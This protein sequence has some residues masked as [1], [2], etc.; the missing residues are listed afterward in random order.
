[1]NR[2]LLL[3]LLVIAGL[4]FQPAQ[5]MKAEDGQ[6]GYG[7]QTIMVY[8][9]G[10][11]LESEGG[12]ATSDIREMLQARPDKERLN[13]LVMTGGTTRWT[14]KI[15]SRDQLGVYRIEGANPKLVHQ[16]ESASMGEADTL[17][18]FLE[19]AVSAY[20]ADSYGLVLWDHGGGPMVGFG[21]DTLYRH[22]E[23]T[24]FELREALQE[25]PFGNGL[26]LEWLAFDACLMASLEVASIME[27]YSAYLVASEETLPSWG[28]DYRFLAG[29]HDTGL[30]GPEVA[31]HIIDKSYEFYEELAAKQPDNSQQVTL[32]V[33]DLSKV[34]ETQQALGGLFSSLDKGLQVGVYSEVARRRDQTKAYGRT[35]TTDDYDLI[36]LT[37]LADNL[38]TLYPGEAETLKTAIA[39]M[40]PYSKANVPRSSGLSI[41][42][43]M[44]NKAFYKDR[45]AKLYQEFDISPEYKAFMEKY[46]KILLGESLGSWT[47]SEAPAV[48]FDEQTGEY[49]IQ[50]SAEQVKDYNSGQYY[51]LVR[52]DGEEY[53]LVYMSSD[54]TL[55]EQHRLHANFN[56]KTMFIEN[57]S[58]QISVVPQMNETENIN[59]I[60]SYQIPMVLDRTDTDGAIESVNASLLAEIDKN[61]GEARITGAIRDDTSG[62]LTGKR[63]V[64][65][66]EWDNAHFMFNSSYLTRDAEGEVLPFG[67]WAYSDSFWLSSFPL[68]DVVAVRYGEYQSQEDEFFVMISVV[69]TQRYVYS[70]ELMPMTARVEKPEETPEITGR[71]QKKQLDFP[72]EGQEPAQLLDSGEI[73]AT[74]ESITLG[75]Q[76]TETGAAP[77]TLSLL[78]RV[79]NLQTEE[80]SMETDWTMVNDHMMDAR[81]F[82]SIPSGET[83][84][85]QIDFPIPYRA[86]GSSLQKSGIEEVSSIRFRFKFSSGFLRADYSDEFQIM[87][88][89]PLGETAKAEQP[90]PFEPVLL[91]Q[92]GGVNIELAGKPFSDETNFYIPLKATNISSGYDMISIAD[93][94]VNGVMASFTLE[95]NPYAGL[96][97]MPSK[98]FLPG[99]VFHL[100]AQIPL[101]RT[102]LPEELKEYQFMFDGL[103][104]LEALGIAQ[105][106]EVSLRF[107]L[108]ASGYSD[109]QNLGKLLLDPCS[110]PLEGMDGQEQALDTQG[111]ELLNLQGVRI[112]RLD[113]DLEGRKLYLFNGSEFTVNVSTSGQ[114]LVDGAA[115]NGNFPIKTTLSPGK[116]AYAKLFDY[117][118]GIEP[119][120]DELSF[121]INLIDRDENKLLAQS[122]K[123]TLPLFRAVEP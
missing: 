15:I 94:S 89:I 65:L 100:E 92:G 43:P 118:P 16:W 41:Y 29:L 34:Q 40:V 111:T 121:Y 42:F 22:D 1:M 13:V 3:V 102:I 105:P 115:F 91:A 107:E 47:G 98:A 45:W 44:A 75:T 38:A 109:D 99:S 33:L 27:P 2:K 60:A 11:D 74:L 64:N 63:D 62:E 117:L 95:E 88:G 23:L 123:I 114:T 85:M 104:S 30:T 50:L 46:G 97:F 4:T 83:T 8:I 78:I 108:D 28:F 10:S 20:P 113:S 106:A 86:V 72:F 6:N 90:E 36:D 77:D 18:Q 122:E 73:K 71:Q 37:D 5:G 79:E 55:D 101:R 120:G 103:N 25:S 70:S 12:M 19:Y 51:V 69:D 39:D 110:I 61:T 67:D 76:S 119:E 17:R 52:L 112:V 53:M 81:S 9:V 7:T 59:G 57:P 56:G 80:I 35:S 116:S 58:G 48:T 21:S 49:F 93:S 87:T 84:R 54:V 66:H 24:L 32:S 82:I 68:K 26:K 31:G 14:A 96:A